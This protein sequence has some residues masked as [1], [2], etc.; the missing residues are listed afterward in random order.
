MK[1]MGLIGTQ[2]SVGV[3]CDVLDLAYVDPGI[4]SRWP[5]ATGMIFANSRITL[6]IFFFFWF[7]LE[8]RLVLLSR[9]F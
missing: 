3:T 4:F 7:W 9:S 1:A 8:G 5:A 6:A 2:W